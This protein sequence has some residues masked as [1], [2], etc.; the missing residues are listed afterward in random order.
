MSIHIDASE[1]NRLAA[2]L[3]NLPKEALPKARTAV[4]RTS[5]AIKATGMALAPVD[6]GNL[7]N[8]ITYE[9]KELADAVEGVIGPTANYGHYV[10]FGTSRMGPHAYMGPALD[11]HGHELADALTQIA[12][13]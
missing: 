10:E 7:L 8:S 13:L 2:D 12:E 3:G 5:A 4:Q 1:L 9:T 6:T 11:R